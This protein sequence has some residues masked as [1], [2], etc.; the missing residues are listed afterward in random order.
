MGTYPFVTSKDVTA[1]GICSDIGLGPKNVTDVMVVFKAYVT[2][3][4]TGPLK[5]ELSPEQTAT[6][7]W[8]EIG[9]VTGR[10]RR[11]AEF[12]FELAKRAIMA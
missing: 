8:Q 5:N 11:A 10:Q 12:D 7:G 4:G 1:S 6:K 9:T 3:V 2:R